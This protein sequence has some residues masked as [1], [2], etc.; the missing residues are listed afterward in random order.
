MQPKKIPTTVDPRYIHPIQPV[1]TNS[2]DLAFT[3]KA[4]EQLHVFDS[5]TFQSDVTLEGD[6]IIKSST[7]APDVHNSLLGLDGGETGYYGHLTATA[8]ANAEAMHAFVMSR[9][10]LGF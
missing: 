1:V 7:E 10:S 3:V 9:V 5:I 6:L 2:D 8:V 4:T